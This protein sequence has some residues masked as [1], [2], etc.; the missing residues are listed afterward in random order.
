MSSV[1]DAWTTAINLIFAQSQDPDS[2]IQDAATKIRGLIGA[3]PSPAAS[4]STA[5]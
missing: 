4:A 5:P 1:W 2:A 3:S